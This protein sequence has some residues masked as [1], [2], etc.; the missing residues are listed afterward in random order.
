MK[1]K[2]EVIS[3]FS[4]YAEEVGIIDDIA[5]LGGVSAYLDAEL[6]GPLRN[7]TPIQF[8]ILAMLNDAEI[9]LEDIF[10]VKVSQDT[11]EDRE[12]IRWH[13]DASLETQ[14]GALVPIKIEEE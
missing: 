9:F 6:F 14:S 4:D 10:P 1:T 3:R 2:G 12:G 5:E 7:K 13:F 11:Y 8:E